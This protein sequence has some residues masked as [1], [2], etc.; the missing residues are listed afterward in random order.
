MALNIITIATFGN[1]SKPLLV[2]LEHNV[3][4]VKVVS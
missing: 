1:Q 2:E 4:T 3:E